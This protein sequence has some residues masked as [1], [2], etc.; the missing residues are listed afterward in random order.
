MFG[1]FPA[2]SLAC[3]G[4]PSID[5]FDGTGSAPKGKK[6]NYHCL[7]DDARVYSTSSP[8]IVLVNEDWSYCYSVKGECYGETHSVDTNVQNYNYD[9]CCD[10]HGYT[11]E[12]ILRDENGLQVAKMCREPTI[13][14][15]DPQYFLCAHEDH[16]APTV[17]KKR[18]VDET[19]YLSRSKRG[20]GD[21]TDLNYYVGLYC[22]EYLSN[23][24]ATESVCFS[25][26]IFPSFYLKGINCI[27]K[28]NL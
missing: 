27:F 19:Q 1:F 25:F 26:N 5:T 24:C 13:G 12:V 9:L 3:V 6:G 16:D 11:D 2:D 4:S 28:K 17:R 20:G 22:P 21:I 15:E 14:G 7:V 10:T 18:S 23:G 8:G